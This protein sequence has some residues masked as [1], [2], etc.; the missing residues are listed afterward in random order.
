MTSVTCVILLKG[1]PAS[2]RMRTDRC[3]IPS[4]TRS[5]LITACRPGCQSERLPM[6]TPRSSI[7]TR[8]TG[9]W[10]SLLSISLALSLLAPASLNAQFDP[11]RAYRQSE[12][13]KQR[14]PD[15]AER[16]DTPGFARGRTDFTSHE[17]M[18]AFISSL[19]RQHDN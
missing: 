18:M 13:V 11:E 15:P 17:E 19:Q 7:G 5:H 9:C 1:C 12:A 10:Q 4:V 3:I 6:L 16:F 8:P 14:Y 2:G